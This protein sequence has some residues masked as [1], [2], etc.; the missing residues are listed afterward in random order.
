MTRPKMSFRADGEV[1]RPFVR[2]RHREL[3]D[4]AGRRDSADFL[5]S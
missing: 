4:R 1:E 3:G 5:F 2:A